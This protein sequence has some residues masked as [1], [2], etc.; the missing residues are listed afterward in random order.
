MTTGRAAYPE[1][2]G[3]AERVNF[4]DAL[5]GLLS[6]AARRSIVLVHNHSTSATFSDDDIARLAQ[7]DSLKGMLV[8]GHDGTQHY[9]GKSD[10]TPA[11][12]QSRL[13]ADYQ[14]YLLR[15]GGEYNARVKSGTMTADEAWVAHTDAV[16][17]DLAKA[18]KLEICEVGWAMTGNPP[19]G[20]NLV[21]FRWDYN[22]SPEDNLRA[23]REAYREVYGEYPPPPSEDDEEG[24]AP[25]PQ[26]QPR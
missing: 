22:K 21:R 26:Q 24:V 7:F 2:H 1:V 18:H 5:M 17:R 14:R 15:H 13:R 20:L 6:T 10:Q 19:C 9:V 8:V 23:Y 25:R 4:P 12:R 16:M 3:T 11:L